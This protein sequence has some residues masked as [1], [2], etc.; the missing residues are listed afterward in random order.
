MTGNITEENLGKFKSLFKHKNGNYYT[1]HWE[2]MIVLPKK[3]DT[4][5][6]LYHHSEVDG[7]VWFIKR[8]ASVEDLR[9]V[10]FAIENEELT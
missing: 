4:K 6:R 8:L 2:Y 5:A 9:A 10:Y 1:N 3:G 7:K